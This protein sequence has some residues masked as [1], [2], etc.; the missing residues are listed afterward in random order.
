MMSFFDRQLLLYTIV[1]RKTACSYHCNGMVA[2]L[3]MVQIVKVNLE[4]T[5]IS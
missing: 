5:E 1:N 2:V 3:P 4:L